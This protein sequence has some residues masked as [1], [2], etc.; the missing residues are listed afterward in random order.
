MKLCIECQEYKT[1]ESFHKKTTAK[2]GLQSKCKLCNSNS[3]REW[4]KENPDRFKISWKKH[5][6]GSEARL[7]KRARV[8]G[9]T[10]E[11]LKSMLDAAGGICDICRQPPRRWLVVDHCHIKGNVRGILCEDC[12]FG[13]GVFR[14]NIKYLENAIEYLKSQ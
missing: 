6:Y 13:L 10:K 8:Y 2:D 14:D 4:Q 1:Y 3:A 7:K 9:L 12:N 11:E 5:S